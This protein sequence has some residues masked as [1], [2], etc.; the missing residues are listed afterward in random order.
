VKHE[1]KQT[2]RRL[3]RKVGREFAGESDAFVQERPRERVYSALAT[4]ADRYGYRAGHL[5][6]AEHRVFSQNGDDGVLAEFQTIGTTNRHFVE[7]GV[8]DGRERNTRFL[9][10]VLGWSGTYFEGD[11]EDCRLVTER[12][13]NTPR[14]RCATP[15]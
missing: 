15:W 14:S 7:F 1:L 3:L 5:T 6:A 12:Y 9:A 10:E 8:Q 13:A 2:G 4:L 11:H